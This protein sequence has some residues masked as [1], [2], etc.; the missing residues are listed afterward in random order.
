MHPPL[1]ARVGDRTQHGENSMQGAVRPENSWVRTSPPRGDVGATALYR[2][3]CIL[4]SIVRTEWCT[5]TSSH[6][7]WSPYSKCSFLKTVGMRSNMSCGVAVQG[8]LEGEN[9]VL[10]LLGSGT[11][12]RVWEVGEEGLSVRIQLR[13]GGGDIGCRVQRCGVQH[14]TLEVT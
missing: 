7:R 1:T 12:C 3:E 2:A 9:H 5:L 10:R 11:A 8:L 4:E 13:V 6:A 14:A